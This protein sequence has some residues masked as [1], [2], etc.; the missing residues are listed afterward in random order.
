[1]LVHPRTSDRISVVGSPRWPKGI[2]I[3][4][5]KSATYRVSTS[6]RILIDSVGG[7]A[8]LPG[9]TSFLKSRLETKIW[10]VDLLAD[11]RDPG[12][13]AVAKEQACALTVTDPA[14]VFA[15]EA[16]ML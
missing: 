13:W 7:F 11:T 8:P 12:I 6:E 2:Y 14:L 10:I 16:R 1:M 5:K 3:H 4:C 15:E 9:M